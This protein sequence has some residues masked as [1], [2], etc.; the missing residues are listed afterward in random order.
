VPQALQPVNTGH[1]PNR[2][3]DEVGLM[4]I[5]RQPADVQRVLHID[6][7]S[8]RPFEAQENECKHPFD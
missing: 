5:A 7:L 6:V 3:Q 2:L 8:A 1:N 4:Q